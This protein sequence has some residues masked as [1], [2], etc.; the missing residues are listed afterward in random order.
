MP[1]LAGPPEA[2]ARVLTLQGIEDPFFDAF[3]QISDQDGRPVPNKDLL[4]QNTNILKMKSM[5]LKNVTASFAAGDRPQVEQETLTFLN[6]RGLCVAVIRIPNRNFI[7]GSH[8][9]TIIEGR[10]S[11]KLGAASWLPVAPDVAVGV[12]IFPNREFLVSLD[13]AND[14]EELIFAINAATAKL[15]ERIAGTSETLVRSL[16]Q[17]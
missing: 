17:T 16:T 11:G 4:Y 10:H 9:I 5:V 8:G 6:E 15:S 14:G 7:I 13:R 3:K 12:T 1:K 2:Q